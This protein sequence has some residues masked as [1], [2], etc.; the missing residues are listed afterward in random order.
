M[1]SASDI[2]L[3]QLGIV[4]PEQLTVPIAVIGAGNI[5]SWVTYNLLKIGCT[6]V[7]VYDG[8]RVELHNTSS[9]L[10]TDKSIGAYKVTA[11]RDTLAGLVPVMPDI[12][13]YNVNLSELHNAYRII[14]GAVDNMTTRRAIYE[15]LK[16]ENVVY[17]DGRL[18]GHTAQVYS[19]RLQE[20][21]DCRLYEASLF[22]DAEADTIPCSLRS[23][24]YNCLMIAGLI[25][26]VVVK[27]VTDRP[28]YSRLELDMT[29]YTLTGG[30]A[31]HT[32][33]ISSEWLGARDGVVVGNTIPQNQPAPVAVTGHEQ[34]RATHDPAIA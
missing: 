27:I 10:Y 3:R 4:S 31:R 28:F 21:E 13:D 9:Q 20:P 29:N 8:D 14:I 26:S 33:S 23:I 16:G 11:L 17:I 12:K 30:L 6:H 24:A 7:T 22:P 15:T 5:G 2:Y 32:Q 25:G 1:N 19:V 18:G 34:R